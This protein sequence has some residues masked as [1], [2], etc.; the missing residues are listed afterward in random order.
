[1]PALD[2]ALSPFHA[3]LHRTEDWDAAVFEGT[4]I[5]GVPKPIQ[6]QPSTPGAFIGTIGSISVSAAERHPFVN[7]AEPRGW[8]HENDLMIGDMGS[9][10]LFIGP[11]GKIQALS[12]CY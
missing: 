1:M 7:V 10:Y 3:V 12:Q 2:E 9:L 5:G 8:S 6:E 4:K 11:D